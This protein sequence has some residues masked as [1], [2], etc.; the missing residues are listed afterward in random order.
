MRELVALFLLTLLE[1]C[2]PSK[3]RCP[4]GWSVSNLKPDGWYTC[5]AP[6]P[7]TCGEDHQ[8]P[9]PPPERRVSRI[10]CTGGS[11]PITNMDGQRVGC[12]MR[13]R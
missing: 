10:H 3:A 9:C 6:L 11:V 4:A 12:Q 7:R 2:P 8:P 1:P 5:D 13:P